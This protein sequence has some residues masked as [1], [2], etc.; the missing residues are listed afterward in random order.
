MF[1]DDDK[2]QNETRNGVQSESSSDLE[3]RG[4]VDESSATTGWIHLL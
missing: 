3:D 4:S 2:V 1:G